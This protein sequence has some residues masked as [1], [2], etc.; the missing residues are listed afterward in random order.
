MMLVACGGGE[1]SSSPP[2]TFGYVSG[3][4]NNTAGLPVEGMMMVLGSG[5]AETDSAGKFVFNHVPAGETYVVRGSGGGSDKHYVVESQSF[6]LTSGAT[7]TF[8]D[9][10]AYEI[11]GVYFASTQPLGVESSSM[12]GPEVLGR[13][14]TPDS[15][16]SARFKVMTENMLRRPV[17]GFTMGS[18]TGGAST[19][20]SAGNV[21]PMEDGGAALDVGWF[22]ITWEKP[23]ETDDPTWIDFLGTDPD[24]KNP[25][26]VWNSDD[27]HEHDGDPIFDPDKP[28]AYLDVY[29]ELDGQTLITG[30]EYYFRIYTDEIEYPAI[31]I[32]FV[33]RMSSF[34][35]NLAVTP[36][37]DRKFTWVPPSGADGYTVIVMDPLANEG[38]GKVI[39]K[40]EGLGAGA[41]EAYVNESELVDGQNAWFVQ[42]IFVKDNGW[43]GEVSRAWDVIVK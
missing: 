19:F 36:A 31:G 28:A 42:A 21:S 33:T 18:S 1:P 7:R 40:I 25:V 26:E 34:P 8:D 2:G 20:S 9:L 13:G 29:S 10:T 11:N 39:T 30:Q 35:E 5:T 38:A 41:T 32:P 14:M 43:P 27:E 17:G 22:Y 4:V 15:P 3:T 12:S 37:P 16:P 6:T 24:T 23:A